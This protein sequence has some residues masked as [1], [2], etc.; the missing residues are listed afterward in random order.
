MEPNIELVDVVDEQNELVKSVPRSTMRAENLI[1]RAAYIFVFSPLGSLCVQQRSA[2]KD[3]FP[4]QWDL[5]A[6]GIP[7]T[8][9]SYSEAALRELGEELGIYHQELNAHGE[10]FY[11]DDKCK[12]WGSIYSLIW[13]GDIT[14]QASEI[15]QWRYLSI[16]DIPLF[17]GAENITPTT[18]KA[19][20]QLLGLD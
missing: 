6:G 12:V 9:E 18:L 3:I 2:N 7:S 19:Y 4:S 14:P 20:H 8:G 10:F 15:S 5:A 16:E 17:L 11:A 1:H 13:D